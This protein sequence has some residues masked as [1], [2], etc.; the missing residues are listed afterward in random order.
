M[1]ET[2][3]AANQLPSAGNVSDAGET[4]PYMHHTGKRENQEESH[5]H[6]DVQLEQEVG[7]GDVFGGAATE[8]DDVL[9]P[10]H[11]LHHFVAVGVLHADEDGA[12]AQEQGGQNPQQHQFVAPG[13]I[14]GEAVAFEAAVDEDNQAGQ[15]HQAE[16]AAHQHG[17]N[18]FGAMRYADEF[19]KP[20]GGEQAEQVAEKHHQ[21]AD[22]KQNVAQAQLA[23]VEQLAGFAFPAV[24]LAVEAHERAEEENRQADIGINAEEKLVK[25]VHDSA[26]CAA[27]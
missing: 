11:Q 18:L 7:F 23:G 22:V 14:G 2:S 8:G 3:A 4:A 10:L 17:E 9:R 13:G 21:Y 20:Q 27:F 24:L 16:D 1:L 5:T 6:K 19:P 15:R 26:P 25:R 12:Q